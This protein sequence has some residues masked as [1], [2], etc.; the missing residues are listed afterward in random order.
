MCELGVVFWRAVPV[1][2]GL[3]CSEELGSTIKVPPNTGRLS[4]DHCEDTRE[5]RMLGRLSVGRDKTPDGC[6]FSIYNLE[7]RHRK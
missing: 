4:H 7:V 5:T 2:T 6:L 1:K 3:V